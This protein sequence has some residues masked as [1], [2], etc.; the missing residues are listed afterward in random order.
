MKLVYPVC[1]YP[2]DDE[3][4]CVDIPDLNC[5]TQ[6][7]NLSNAIEMAA[8]A[9]AGWLLDSLSHGEKIPAPSKLE[10]VSPDEGGFISMVLVDL[11]ALEKNY[12]DKS[13][14][15]T[16]TIPSWLNEAAEKNNVN[17]SAVLKDALLE[18][19]ER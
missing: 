6:G 15:K 13:I 16:L 12:S 3:S 5:S 18:R 10:N 2:N 7:E 4:Y 8:D 1:F 17:F 19:L 9:A 14:K 11:D